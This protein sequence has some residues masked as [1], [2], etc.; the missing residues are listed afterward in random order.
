MAD[1]KTIS[2]R[3]KVGGQLG[4]IIRRWSEEELQI[5]RENYGKV[6]GPATSKLLSNRSLS[7]VQKIAIRYRIKR[8]E[9]LADRDYRLRKKYGIS[10]K[11][12]HEILIKQR[13]VCAIC[14]NP[15]IHKD[16]TGKTQKLSVDH[17]HQTGKVRGLLCK[18]C[19]FVLGSSHENTTTLHNA[20]LYLEGRRL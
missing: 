1:T 20:I 2:R 16:L 10:E 14:G 7:A 6:G 15:E 18:N 12:Y 13:N 3:K 4:A 11:E 19:N 9:G 8:K 5:V 17:N